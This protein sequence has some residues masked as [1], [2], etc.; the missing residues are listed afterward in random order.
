MR[1][2]RQ[3]DTAT[4]FSSNSNTAKAEVI[5]VP[6]GMWKGGMFCIEI[7]ALTHD[8]D[9]P[10]TKIWAH[11]QEE[12]E[13]NVK[14]HLETAGKCGAVSL[15]NGTKPNPRFKKKKVHTMAVSL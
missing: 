10:T 15:T 11:S 9:A 7:P 14:K 1:P 3:S 2:Q 13:E 12:A 8:K 5:E 4:N 6:M